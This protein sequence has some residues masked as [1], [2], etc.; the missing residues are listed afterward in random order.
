M[1]GFRDNLKNCT[2]GQVFTKLNSIE[3]YKKLGI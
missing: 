3:R 1:Q 2:A